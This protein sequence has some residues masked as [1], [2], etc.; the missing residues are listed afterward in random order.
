MPLRVISVGS[1]RTRDE[2]VVLQGVDK[3]GP[4]RAVLHEAQGCVH[5]AGYR[6]RIAGPSVRGEPRETV[7]KGDAE[8][9]PAG[10]HR[11]EVYAKL[12]RECPRHLGDPDLEHYL[13]HAAHFQKVDN[14]CFALLVDRG[15]RLCHRR[16]LGEPDSAGD[17]AGKRDGVIHRRYPYIALLGEHLVQLGFQPSNIGRHL[18]V[19][20][21]RDR[22]ALGPQREVRYAGDLAC[23]ID[24][25]GSEDERVDDVR[26][27][28]RDPPHDNRTFY[29]QR[30]PGRYHDLLRLHR[31][32]L[33]PIGACSEARADEEEERGRR[34]GGDDGVFEEISRDHRSHSPCSNFTELKAVP[35][36]SSSV[37]DRGCANGRPGLC[38]LTF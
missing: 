9:P 17:R 11:V 8:L 21:C 19:E 23:D 22:V 7:E 31:I 27:G 33:N 29:D 20:D 35:F 12:V 32:D 15:V 26:S 34:H 18:N 6:E 3:G 37:T 36:T 5:R 38:V 10:A 16:H 24:L 14:F 4:C 13:L 1:A 2:S 25:T 28:H 30:L